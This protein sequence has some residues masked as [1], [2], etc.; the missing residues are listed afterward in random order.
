[1]HLGLIGLFAATDIGDVLARALI[2]AQGA[3]PRDFDPQHHSRPTHRLRRDPHRCGGRG[4]ASDDGE[5]EVTA[6]GSSPLLVAAV[7]LAI[8]GDNIGVYVPVFA[9]VGGM[10]V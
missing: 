7:T 6:G 10:T 4:T 3:G 8:G 5:A 9:S 2:F 1:M